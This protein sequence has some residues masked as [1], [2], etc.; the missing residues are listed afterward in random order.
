MGP[1]NTEEVSICVETKE[2]HV[3]VAQR[4]CMHTHAFTL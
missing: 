3:H 4:S 1:I 2:A